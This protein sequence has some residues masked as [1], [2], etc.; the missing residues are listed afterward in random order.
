MRGEAASQ[1]PPRNRMVVSILALLG[2]LVSLYMLAH[3]LGLAVGTLM[4]GLG[5]CEKVQESPYAWIGPIPVAGLGKLKKL[6][7]A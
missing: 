6:S 2:L 5:D 3:A 7:S 4:C 1:P